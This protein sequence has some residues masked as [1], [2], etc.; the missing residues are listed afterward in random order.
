MGYSSRTGRR[1]AEYASKSAHGFLVKDAS[2]QE[3]LEHCNLPKEAGEVSFDGHS[4]FVFTPPGENPI[5]HIVAIDGGYTEVVVQPKFPSATLAFFQFGALVFDTSDLEGLEHSAFIDPADMEKLK[6]I[7]RIKLS[8]PIRNITM[9]GHA[10]LTASI[11][12]LIYRFFRMDSEDGS[13]LETLRWLIFREFD[14]PVPE[15][16][17]ANCPNCR[18]ASI[19]LLRSEMAPDGLFQCPS[20]AGSI[21]LT[22]VL[23][24]HEAIDDEL[25]AGEILGYVMTAIEQIILVH[26]IRVI[27]ATKPSLLSEVVFIK[28]GPLGFFGQTANLHK[29][30][31]ELVSFLIDKHDLYLAG[32]EK[33]GS[34]VEHAHEIEPLLSPG[35]V[36]LLDNDYIYR[37]I[38]PGK[39]DPANPYGRTTY[40]GNKLI[41]KSRAEKLHVV[42]LPTKNVLAKPLRADFHNIDV[43]LLNIEKLKCDMYDDSLV[44]VALVNKL[45]SLAD[46]PSSRILQKFAIKTMAAKP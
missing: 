33:S 16:T 14:A 44:P 21:Y 31:R 37:Y 7:Q 25:G 9:K 39:A 18:K 41:F 5:K 11:R 28:D 46:H 26:L 24:L 32:F 29:P 40:Y 22:D 10:S 38:I 15:W 3:F 1:P 13:L 6:R 27:L 8:L 36:L 45:V 35:D 17:L 2:I 30:V 4:K 34:F 43:I 20:C 19:P 42:T 23:R 12:E